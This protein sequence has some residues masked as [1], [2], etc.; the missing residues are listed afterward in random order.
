MELLKT[1]EA[2]VLLNIS[3]ATLY[4]LIKSG[5]IQPIRLHRD[6]RFKKQDLIDFVDSKK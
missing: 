1:K 6:L 4:R 2:I 3:R 5:D